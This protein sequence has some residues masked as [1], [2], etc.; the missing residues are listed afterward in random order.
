MRYFGAYAMKDIMDIFPLPDD[1][2]SCDM[3]I[4]SFDKDFF[5][6]QKKNLFLTAKFY[7]QLPKKKTKLAQEGQISLP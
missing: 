6:N 4:N 7:S 3:S 1:A 2:N 5:A